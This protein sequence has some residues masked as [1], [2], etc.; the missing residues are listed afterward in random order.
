MG[1]GENILGRNH[2]LRR[3]M[4]LGRGSPKLGI[5]SKVRPQAAVKGKVRKIQGS[6]DKKKKIE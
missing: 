6:A 2:Y 5:K 3:D 1:G 4:G